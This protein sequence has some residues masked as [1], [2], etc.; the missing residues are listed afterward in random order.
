MRTPAKLGLLA[1]LYF[2]QGLPFGFFTQALPALMR[3]QGVSL[4]AIGLST[5]LALPWGLKF[6]WAPLVDRHAHARAGARRGWLLPLQ[7]LSAAVLVALAHA[8]PARSLTWL[9]V[10]V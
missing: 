6:L 8:D 1:T 3:Q 2:S 4:A 9:V 7:L 10:G 5:L